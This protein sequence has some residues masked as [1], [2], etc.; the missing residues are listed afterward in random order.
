[1]TFSTLLR[2]TIGSASL[3]YRDQTRVIY[4]NNTYHIWATKLTTGETSGW[5]GRVAHLTASALGGPWSE[6][7]VAIDRPGAGTQIDS[8]DSSFYATGALT[9]SVI[10]DRGIWWMWFNTTREVTSPRA[11]AARAGHAFSTSPN[12]P[13]TVKGEFLPKAILE[14]DP[15]GE[16][17]HAAVN[18]SAMFIDGERR[19][20]FRAWNPEWVTQGEDRS[21]T[22]STHGYAVCDKD[23]E[24]RNEVT[25]HIIRVFSGD[26]APFIN[27]RIEGVTP[28]EYA[29]SNIVTSGYGFNSSVG[30]IESSS[31]RSMVWKST[32]GQKFHKV[33]E[34]IIQGNGDQCYGFLHGVLGS[35][36][37]NRVSSAEVAVYFGDFIDPYIVSGETSIYH[38][39]TSKRAGLSARARLLNSD[40]NPMTV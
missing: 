3:Y 19:I 4:F 31:N 36:W 28:T 23:W 14:A 37:F 1:M 8:E 16:W 21:S 6:A 26:E 34:I 24:V 2:D 30:V 32:D 5:Y 27:K 13:W 11:W 15:S 39:F 35:T 18:M 7:D 29:D 20:Y 17:W 12:G 33:D 10:Y 22:Y 40:K 25:R 9:P 38:R